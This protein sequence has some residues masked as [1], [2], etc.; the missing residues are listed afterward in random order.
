MPGIVQPAAAAA[1]V[2]QR[3]IYPLAVIEEGAHKFVQP[4]P[5]CPWDEAVDGHLSHQQHQ[6]RLDDSEL[7][8]QKRAAE[9]ALLRRRLAVSGAR[10]RRARKA[11]RQRRQEHA[12][13][14]VRGWEAGALKPGPQDATTRAGEVMPSLC[15]YPARRLADQH[16]ICRGQVVEERASAHDVPALLAG[17]TGQH[18]LFQPA[19]RL[20][21][22][23]HGDLRNG[24][25]VWLHRSRGSGIEHKYSAC[26]SRSFWCPASPLIARPDRQGRARGSCRLGHAALG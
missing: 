13:F 22:A 1:R 15:R 2:G 20:C 26:R 7:G 19:Q 8:L 11:A 16:D 24:W 6:P 18:L 14:E 25:V 12:A 3:H 10:A 5:R 17:T 9:R 21:P 4:P 23:R